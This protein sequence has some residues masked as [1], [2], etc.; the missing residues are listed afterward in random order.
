VVARD[1]RLWRAEGSLRRSGEALHNSVELI[2]G[3]GGSVGGNGD[4]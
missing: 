2:S 1:L 4:D 3:D